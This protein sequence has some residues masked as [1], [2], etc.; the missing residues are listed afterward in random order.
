[1]CAT[2]YIMVFEVCTQGRGEVSSVRTLQ[3]S[4]KEFVSVFFSLFFPS[5]RNNNIG[6]PGIE[7][8]LFNARC[9]QCEHVGGQPCFVAR[10]LKSMVVTTDSDK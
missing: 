2:L 7:L 1:M 8:K 6:I 3:I 10:Y 5:L 4:K 9:G